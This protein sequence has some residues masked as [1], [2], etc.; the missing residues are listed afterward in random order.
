MENSLFTQNQKLGSRTK[1][2]MPIE[3][4]HKW[5]VSCF[6]QKQISVSQSDAVDFISHWLGNQ[7]AI[8]LP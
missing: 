5:A 2:L 1:I 8:F 4:R 7:L 6:T 3:Q